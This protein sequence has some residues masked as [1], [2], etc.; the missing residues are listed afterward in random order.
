M[1][2]CEKERERL[3]KVKEK[4]QRVRKRERDEVS[5]MELRR[6][7]GEKRGDKLSWTEGVTE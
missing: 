2:G 3:I 5:R 7:E 1:S 4:M 6:R